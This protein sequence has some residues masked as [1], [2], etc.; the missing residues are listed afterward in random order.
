MVTHGTCS[1]EV[2]LPEL[3]LGRTS[4]LMVLV[5]ASLVW[6]TGAPHRKSMM[7]FLP[8]SRWPGDS[9]SFLSPGPFHD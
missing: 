7:L 3:L 8:H 6:V 4:A 5:L 1:A 9:G 2:L